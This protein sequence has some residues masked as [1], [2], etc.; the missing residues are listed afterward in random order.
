MPTLEIPTPLR[1]YANNQ[2]VVDV[3]GETVSVVID[4]LIRQFPT[5]EKHLKDKNGNLRSFVNV[6]VGDE[7][8]RSLDGLNTEV[9]PDD[10]L[11]II[12][13]IAGGASSVS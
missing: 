5:L 2:T 13:S 8:I 12:P 9:E 11:I 1:P 3:A 10:A 6:F 7:D 4:D